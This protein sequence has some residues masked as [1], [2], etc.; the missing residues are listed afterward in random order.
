[1]FIDFTDIPED[2][3]EFDRLIV[4]AEQTGPG[5]AELC[6]GPVRLVGRA[7]PGRRGIELE[8]ELTATVRQECSR[9]LDPLELPLRTRFSLIVVSESSEFGIGEARMATEDSMLFHAGRGRVDLREVVWE[10]ICLD[11]PLKPVCR[12]D[13]AGL[14]PTC[15]VNR[16]GIECPCRSAEVDPRLAPLLDFR[17]KTRGGPGS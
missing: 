4:L 3:L 2:G 7:V 17:N 9:C 5:A 8:G 1:V 6:A 10:Q 12:P 16:N 15:G 14:C 11:L 13:C